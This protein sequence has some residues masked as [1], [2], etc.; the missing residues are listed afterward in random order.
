MSPSR[1]IKSINETFSSSIEEHLNNQY[2]STK[3]NVKWPFV[4]NQFDRVQWKSGIVHDLNKVKTNLRVY[5]K[6]FFFYNILYKI[7]NYEYFWFRYKIMVMLII[8]ECL[9]D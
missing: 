9:H 1:S 6:C 3:T 2:I 4:G 7:Y 8:S 5:Y